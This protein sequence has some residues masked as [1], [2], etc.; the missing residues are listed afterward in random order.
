MFFA[1]VHFQCGSFSSKE[2]KSKI[3]AEINKDNRTIQSGFFQLI[4]IFYVINFYINKKEGN[5]QKSI[6]LPNTFVPNKCKK[7][8]KKKDGL[9]KQT[10]SQKSETRLDFV[11]FEAEK[12]PKRKRS[13][14]L[15]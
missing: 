12:T 4:H 13:T 15:K 5:D 1:R 10:K 11:V 14:H 2:R 3:T 6:Q 7:K 9:W 8:K